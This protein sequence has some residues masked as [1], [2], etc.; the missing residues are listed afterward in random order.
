MVETFFFNIL[1]LLAFAF[2]LGEVFKRL[3]LSA[4]VGQMVAGLI[5]GPSLFNIVSTSDEFEILVELSIFFLIFM[6]GLKL[7]PE[8]IKKSSKK[9]IGLS[10]LA[11]AIPF[12]ASYY[13][14]TLLDFEFL[15]SLFVAL[16]LAITAVPVSAAVL[17]EFKVLQ[18]KLGSTIMT[19]GIIDDI[20]S[21]VVLGIVLQMVSTGTEQVNYLNLVIFSSKIIAFIGGIFVLD[22]VLKRTASWLK[23]R[24]VKLFE[25]LHTQEAGYGVLLISTIGLSLLA[26]SIGLHYVV[27]TFFAGLIIYK[28]IIGKDNYEQ[29]NKVFSPITFGFFAPIFFA[30][31][32]TQLLVSQVME[33]SL[34]FLILLAVAIVGKI[35]G[36][37]IG[38]RIS[39]FSNRQSSVIGYIMNGRGMVEL[40]IATIGLEAGLLD[41]RLFSIIVAIGFITTL[42]TPVMARAGLTKIQKS[43]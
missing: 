32:G 19:A 43:L 3:K 35:G 25:K 8:E 5:V 2:A 10:I 30:Y 9:A 6:A 23:K 38:G 39:G 36:G 18:T 13:V 42:M 21:L 1:V 7:K 29:I 33:S 34:L 20:I 22:F 40:V 14:M 16:T 12:V 41:M 17:M 27:G 11:F 31:I 26:E 24:A 37:Y 4:I 28:K 15:V